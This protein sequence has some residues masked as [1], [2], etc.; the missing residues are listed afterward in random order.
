MVR[1]IIWYT[2]SAFYAILFF[3]LLLLAFD[4][5]KNGETSEPGWTVVMAIMLAV[6]SAIT[7]AIAYWIGSC[8]WRAWRGPA[9]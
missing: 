1:A 5:L 2:V 6:S 8:E 9:Q 4:A 3:E 7:S